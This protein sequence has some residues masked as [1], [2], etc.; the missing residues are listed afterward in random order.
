MDKPIG[1]WITKRIL[2]QKVSSKLKSLLLANLP[3][4]HLVISKPQNR[5]NLIDEITDELAK[6][7]LDMCQQLDIMYGSDGYIVESGANGTLV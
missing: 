3:N 6:W 7:T 5:M 4:C 2:A 1:R